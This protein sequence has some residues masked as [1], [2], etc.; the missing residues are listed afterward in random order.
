MNYTWYHRYKKLREGLHYSSTRCQIRRQEGEKWSAPTSP[1]PGVNRVQIDSNQYH[2][3]HNFNK[4]IAF[5]SG[6]IPGQHLFTCFCTGSTDFRLN[7]WVQVTSSS[8]SFRCPYSLN[9]MEST[10]RQKLIYQ[11]FELDRFD[12]IYDI[13]E[14]SCIS[15]ENLKWR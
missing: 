4:V 3:C 9:M 10:G 2:S 12:I 14:H 13:C 1:G 11:H 8:R 7:C 6:V 15:P 5:C